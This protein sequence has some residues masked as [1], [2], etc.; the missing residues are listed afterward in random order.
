LLEPEAIQAIDEPRF[1]PVE[2]AAGFMR[3]GERVIGLRIDG[4]SRAYPIA[5]L[6]VH[7]IVNDVV[8]GEPVAVTWCPLCFTA[9][10]YSRWVQGEDEAL[11]FGVSGSLLYETLVMVDRGSG[12]LWSQLYGAAVDGPLKGKRL[13]FFASVLTEW[14]AWLAENPDSLVLNKELTCAQF[15][16]DRFMEGPEQAYQD[17]IYEAYYASRDLGVINKE[18]PG[19]DRVLGLRVGAVARAYA[20]AI[21]GRLPVIN[22]T[23]DRVPVVI[24][25]DPTSETGAAYVRQ[26]DAG[27]LTFG[28]VPADPGLIA[29]FETGSLWQG[30]TG[31][32]IDGPLKGAQLPAV[33]TTTAFEF[34]WYDY[35]PNSQTYK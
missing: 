16:C 19:K 24:W 35:F 20:F 1:V 30:R 8:G 6:S 34:G 15:Q 11:S 21:L 7:E 33:V 31:R 4:D 23:L 22:D 10:V 32:A 13:S 18:I 9:L 17:D 3:P 27:L 29:D 5:I 25:F 2:E 26:S 14:S 28:A 12:S